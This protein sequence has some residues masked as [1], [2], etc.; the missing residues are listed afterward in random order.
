MALNVA[1]LAGRDYFP[2]VVEE[3]ENVDEA[4]ASGTNTQPEKLASV[5][6]A[7]PTDAVAEE[8]GG[9]SEAKKSKSTHVAEGEG[10]IKEPTV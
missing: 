6:P 4:G 9:R 8:D 10:E 7:P 5:L 2:P 1:D 3:D